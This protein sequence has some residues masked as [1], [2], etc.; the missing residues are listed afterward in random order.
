MNLGL[1]KSKHMIKPR[2]LFYLF[3]EGALLL[4]VAVDLEKTNFPGGLIN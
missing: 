3:Y 1:H 4:E 2:L